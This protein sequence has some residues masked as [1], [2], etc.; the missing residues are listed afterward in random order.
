M[1][2]NVHAAGLESHQPLTR[3]LDENHR[4]SHLD[5]DLLVLGARARNRGLLLAQMRYRKGRRAPYII[6][7]EEICLPGMLKVPYITYGYSARAHIHP[8]EISDEW[9]CI[10]TPLGDL[11]LERAWA[12]EDMLAAVALGLALR[13]TPEAMGLLLDPRRDLPQAA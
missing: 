8:R 9:V 2:T 1:I 11:T 3:L 5:V 6:L 13:L 12:L 4:F 10:R 7:P